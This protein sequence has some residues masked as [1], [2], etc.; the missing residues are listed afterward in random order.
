MSYIFHRREPEDKKIIVVNEQWQ[1]TYWMLTLQTTQ[2]KLVK[3]LKTVG[4]DPET[5]K[6]YLLH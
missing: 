4:T 6:R 5:V 3:A 2:D 1:I